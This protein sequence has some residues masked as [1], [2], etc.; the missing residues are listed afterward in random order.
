MLTLLHLSDKRAEDQ[1]KSP[2]VASNADLVVQEM[3]QQEAE[4]SIKGSTAVAQGILGCHSVLVVS[5]FLYLSTCMLS[6]TLSLLC[7]GDRIWLSKSL[8]RLSSFGRLETVFSCLLTR[9]SGWRR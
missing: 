8:S 6:S 5:N 3:P 2:V 1:P 7:L 9:R 4:K